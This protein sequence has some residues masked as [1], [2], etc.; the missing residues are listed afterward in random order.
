MFKTKISVT[1]DGSAAS[2][3]IQEGGV[4]GARSVATGREERA[5]AARGSAV[6]QEKPVIPNLRLLLSCENTPSLRSPATSPRPRRSTDTF[7]SLTGDPRVNSQRCMPLHSSHPSLSFPPP[8]THT[9]SPP[10][11]SITCAL[12]LQCCMYRRLPGER[13]L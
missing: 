5:T 11:S 1:R 7:Y 6:V 4:R 8:H 9:P 2:V 12:N 10:T 13:M 3:H